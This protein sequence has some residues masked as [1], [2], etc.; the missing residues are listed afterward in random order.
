MSFSMSFVDSAKDVAGDVVSAGRRETQRRRLQFRARRLRSRVVSRKAAVGE[1]LYELFE[2]GTLHVDAPGIREQM[3]TISG[4]LAEIE[5]VRAEI[6]AQ[7]AG[8]GATPAVKTS[9]ANID[10]NAAPAAA[11]A[12]TFSDRQAAES[13]T[14]PEEGGQG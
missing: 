4:L 6:E 5:Q 11:A 1:S 7:R 2:A 3:V 8:H 13:G 10:A 12:Q 9:I 14:P